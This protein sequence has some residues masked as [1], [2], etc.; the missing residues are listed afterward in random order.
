MIPALGVMPVGGIGGSIGV[1]VGGDPRLGMIPNIPGSARRGLTEGIPD[2][3]AVQRQKENYA[4]SLEEQL[5]KGVEVLAAT[6]KQQTDMLHAQANEEKHRYNVALD[7]QVKAREL[8]LSQQY[9]EQL[10]RLQQAA[11]AQR[12]DLEQQAC[13]LTLEYQQ[14]KVQEE[15]VAQQEGIQK[16]HIEAQSK[17]DTEI[18]TMM[19][20][21]PGANALLERVQANVRIGSNQPMASYPNP[22]AAVQQAPPMPVAPTALRPYVPP[23]TMPMAAPPKVGGSIL[24][25]LGSARA[26]YVSQ[27]TTGSRPS[28]SYIPSSGFVGP[29]GRPLGSYIPPGKV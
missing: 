25:P 4:K 23:A 3:S 11:Q 28:L 12:A 5:R 26:G 8:Q 9:N 19:K 17:L 15:Y 10:M 21:L 14:R 13:G 29:P 7:Q 27:P 22:F 18:Q 16:Q 24:G 20:A 2:P 6:H 1:P